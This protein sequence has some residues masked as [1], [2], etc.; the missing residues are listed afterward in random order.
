[1]Y[2]SFQVYDGYDEQA[3]LLGEYCGEMRPR[4]RY[5]TAS[6]NVVYIVFRSRYS[7]EGSFFKVRWDAMMTRSSTGM[8]TP[9]PMN[10]SG[11]NTMPNKKNLYNGLSRYCTPFII[12]LVVCGGEY[13]VTDGNFTM[14]T[15]PGF[16]TGYANNLACTWDLT[17]DPHYRIAMTLI[18]LDMEAGTCLYDRVDIYNGGISNRKPTF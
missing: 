16:P 12:C 5:A 15:S 2:G 18:T 7:R 11:K 6:G 4:Q 14:V 8:M 1:M 17:A 9:S 3:P 13:F 10:S